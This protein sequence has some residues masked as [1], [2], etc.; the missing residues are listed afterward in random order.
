MSKTYR[1]ILKNQIVKKKYFIL[2][3]KYFQKPL[4]NDSFYELFSFS[5][6]LAPLAAREFVLQFLRQNRYN[7]FF[8]P[9]NRKDFFLQLLG[10]LDP[11]PG[12]LMRAEKILQN[13]FTVF[14][15]EHRYGRKVRW[16]MDFI[17]S[18][19]LSLKRFYSDIEL[20][21]NGADIKVP[22]EIS[23]FQWAWTLG[24]AY[25]LSGRRVFKEK[26]I[27][28]AKDW[29]QDNPFCIGI[30]WMTPMEA[31]IR[32]C[33]LIAAFYFFCDEEEHLVSDSKD[34]NAVF[35]VDLLKSLYQHGLYLE[36]NLEF[37][38]RSG[39]HLIADAVGLL[40][41]GVFFRQTEKGGE[42]IAEAKE[43]LE[44]EI[45]R[46]TY[47]DGVD[48]EMSIAYHRMV[49][50]MLL[51][52]Y[53]FAEIN[54]VGF[55]LRFRDRLLRMVEFILFYTR[56]NNLAPLIG[57]SDDGRLF[58]FNPDEDFND[59]TS[60]LSLAAAFFERRD[61]KREGD[62]FSEQALWLVGTNGWEVFQRLRPRDESIRSRFFP[63]SQIAIMRTPT[64]HCIV[65]CGELGKEGWGGHGHNDTLGFELYANGVTFISDSGTLCYTANPALRN[66]MR[67]TKAHNTVM[68]DGVEIADFTGDF[69]IDADHTHPKVL[70]WDTSSIEDVLVAEH[71]AY[72]TRLEQPLTHNRMFVFEK[73]YQRLTVIDRLSGSGTHTAE[74]CFHLCPNAEVIKS[75]YNRIHVLDPNSGQ[76]MDVDYEQ[77]DEELFISPGIFAPRY[78]VA[79]QNKVLIFRKKFTDK[80]TF[81]TIFSIP[82]VA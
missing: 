32:A 7:F 3:Q 46:Q 73:R 58:W 54:Q 52:A 61:F 47:P 59:H 70:Q 11:Q 30:N 80:M 76:R 12:P 72:R 49:T 82:S 24:K 79:E 56:P 64:M 9:Q 19:T 57:D 50:E 25:W 53:I 26:F 39:N 43:I 18:N 20:P 68:V 22:W 23:R 29:I 51:T 44:H 55:S 74:I 38:R 63:D 17:S 45:I 69:R 75:S 37:T 67:S 21:K 1:D 66:E 28:L 77:T 42:W 2:R 4:V 6:T 78:G 5:A 60:I 71:Y 48:Y 81:K 31:A 13:T 16:D 62:R 65:D 34:H 14:G 41:L 27:E 10:Q 8:N 33:N 15:A 36:S 35:W 40:M